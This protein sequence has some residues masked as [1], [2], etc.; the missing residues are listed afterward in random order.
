[1]ASRGSG[2]RVKGANFERTIAKYLTEHT[3]IEWKRGIGQTR[4]GGKEISDVLSDV[5][6]WIHIECKNQAN[7]NIKKAMLQAIDDCGDK[8]PVVISKDTGK[9][10]LVTMRLEDWIEWLQEQ[11]RLGLD[12]SKK[13]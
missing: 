12:A 10:T 11:I 1:M 7:C 6:T 3:K 9:D 13:K 2:A 8:I 4:G 5:I